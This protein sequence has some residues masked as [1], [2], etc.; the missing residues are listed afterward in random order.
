[1]KTSRRGRPLKPRATPIGVRLGAAANND[2]TRRVLRTTQTRAASP[3]DSGTSTIEPPRVKRAVFIPALVIIL[4]ALA[5]ATW[6]GAVYGE[7]AT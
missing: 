7:G 3:D 2:Q 5:A 1:N 4:I 6:I